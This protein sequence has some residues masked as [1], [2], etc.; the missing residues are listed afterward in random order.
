MRILFPDTKQIPERFSVQRIY[1]LLCLLCLIISCLP[2]W[3]SVAHGGSLS[4]V[5]PSGASSLVTIY[6]NGT[7][8]NTTAGNNEVAFT[9]TSGGTITVIPTAVTTI[10]STIGLRR[11][12][13]K[14]PDA[15]PVGRAALRVRNKVSGEIS[16]GIS[17]EIIEISLSGVT[18]APVG[19]ANLNVRIIGSANCQFIAGKTRAA[20]GT[21]VTVNSTTV[22]SLT[23]LTA[24]I[25]VSPTAAIGSRSI[26]VVTNTQTAIRPGA[27]TIT[28]AATNNAPV[29]LPIGNASLD[30]GT[31]LDVTVSATDT[32]G[33]LITL[34]TS[35]LPVFAVFTAV[36]GTGTLT[37]SPDYTNAGSY[38]L[39]FTATD[40]KGASASAGMVV[41]VR[42]INRS[43][44]LDPIGNQTVREG[45]LLSFRVDGSDP[46][47]D[48]LGFTV[49]NLPPGAGFDPGTRTF[50]YTP[51]FDVS[52]RTADSFFDVFFEISDGRGGTANETVRITVQNV[53]RPPVA[54]AGL[55]QTAFV[56]NPVS[57]DG[58]GSSDLDGDAL[59]F[60]WSVA[61]RPSGSNATLTNPTATNPAFTP[62]VAGTYIVQLIVNDGIADSA[63][64]TVAVTVTF[65]G[66]D[67]VNWITN[68]N[69]LWQTAGNWSTGVLPGPSD[70]VCIDVPGDITVTHSQGADS[71]SSLRSNEA[72]VLSGG[73]IS[74]ANSAVLSGA[75]TLSGGTLTGAAN[76]ISLGLFTI[77]SGTLGGSGTVTVTGTMTWASGTMTGTG[78]TVIAAGGTLNISGSVNLRGGRTLRNEGTANWNSGP[79]S[80]SYGESATIENIGTWNF[81]APD[82]LFAGGGYGDTGSRVF[83]NEGTLNRTTTTGTAT[84][85]SPFI[86]TGTVNVQ[87]GTLALSSSYT[88]TAGAT[89]LDGGSLT[90][91]TTLNIQGG[92]LA[93]FGAVTA[94]VSNTGGQV[95]P[96]SPLGIL[97]IAGAYM[98]SGSGSLDIELGGLNAGA[99][100]DRF[101]V[102]GSATLSSA[103]NV[104]LING[105]TPAFRDSFTITTSN[106]R[107]GVFTTENMPLLGGDLICCLVSYG[108]P[109]PS[110]PGADFFFVTLTVTHAN[111]PPVITST[112]GTQVT[113]GQAYLYDVEVADPN[114]GEV[115]TFS[116]PVAPEGM[117]IDTATGLIQ[118]TPFFS[119]AGPQ[120]VTVRVQDFDGLVATQDFTV[121]V[122][123]PAGR[124]A[125]V[126]E[127]DAYQVRAN[128]T[129]AVS[130]PGVLSNDTNPDGGSM[131]A[132]FATPPINGALSFN[133]DGS[134]TYTPYALQQGQA[135]LIEEIN[136]AQ[137][138]PGATLNVSSVTPYSPAHPAALAVDGSPG[139]SWLSTNWPF[140]YNFIEIAFPQDV[141]VSR[142]QVYGHRDTSFQADYWIRTG[143]FQLFD[144]AGNELFNSGPITLSVPDGDGEVSVPTL[145]GVRRARF[146]DT[147]KK[148]TRG[149]AEFRVIGSAFV[150]RAAASPDNNLVQLLAT[151]VRA[152]YDT[153]NPPEGAIDSVGG[154]FSTNWYRGSNG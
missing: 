69:G 61:S 125:L 108:I 31:S 113:A 65:C 32:D 137:A 98:Q 43:P 60:L 103:L 13:V 91:T 41:T 49:G 145:S 102:T 148:G 132:M 153:N 96:G 82:V 106:S 72:I 86:N 9:S 6:I 63:P 140:T 120:P 42:D 144:A 79:I 152:Q 128:E 39:T 93:G 24:N 46:D 99:H 84:V 78:T 75:L 35:P 34:T 40:S 131:T 100:Y 8:F 146:T 87:S 16:E 95:S 147:E 107:S 73:S 50:N 97:T 129:L 74:I 5:T 89:I 38:N 12:T 94:N 33:D 21:G 55:N 133:P 7:G 115:L 136:L 23:S 71:I 118:W 27:F 134:F 51:G 76:V 10:D 53:N 66:P 28:S 15:S 57:L 59:T 110:R 83:R 101:D 130:A 111:E 56:T 139:T 142:L 37:L 109:D 127:D 123:L 36:N 4:S 48:A 135:V 90:S 68:A 45:E 88:Q 105:F 114:T 85:G 143:F 119:Q 26:G 150:Q 154:S 52:G 112:P 3:A 151:R 124:H 81:A 44:S 122:A 58:S 80:G 121:E 70:D 17:V 117:T 25:T 22:E 149:L 138:V 126:A 64:S 47:G 54:D 18:S 67:T 92:R 77:T 116:L 11:L 14:V 20:F 29:I 141:A 19:T 62:D 104:S 2:L 30:E 1:L